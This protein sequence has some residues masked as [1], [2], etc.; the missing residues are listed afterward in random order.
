MKLSFLPL[1]VSLAA[2]GAGC[3]NDL[4]MFEKPLETASDRIDGTLPLEGERAIAL[5][6]SLGSVSLHWGG[7]E[8]SIRWGLS[9]QV[10]GENKG[11]A[12]LLLGAVGLIREF[13]ASHDTVRFFAQA[14]NTIPAYTFQT[15]ISLGVPYDSMSHLIID[16]VQGTTDVADLGTDLRIRNVHAVT[17]KRLNA[18]CDILSADG[19]V[20]CEVAIPP[21]GS[22]VITATH[23]TITLKIPTNTSANFSAHATNGIVSYSN[24]AF[25]GLVQRADSLSGTLGAGNGQIRLETNEGNIVIQGI[26][27]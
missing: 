2:L 7:V 4:P 26:L 21:A 3:W 18:S 9:R 11:D 8:D 5:N 14:P 19:G 13:S 16:G 24:L 20:N 1:C 15:L 12:A 10:T 23:G 17:V 6:N 25:T 22:C 27:P